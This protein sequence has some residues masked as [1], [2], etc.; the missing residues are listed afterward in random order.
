MADPLSK[1]SRV[2]LAA[3]PT[4]LTHAARF[5]AAIGADVWIKRD[6]V[7]ALGL[8]G[9]KVRKLEFLLAE[10]IAG[11]ADTIVT[12]GTRI[13]NSARAAAASCAQLGLRCVLIL[14]GEEPPTASGNL[15]LDA[16]FGA[17]LRYQPTIQATGSVRWDRL[18]EANRE[19][20][21]ALISEGLRPYV[22]PV[23]CSSPHA[24]LGFASGYFELLH[25][26]EQIHVSPERLYHASTS[27]GTHAGLVLGHLLAG[28]GPRPYGIGAADNV[29][30]DMEKRYAELVH[31]GGDLIG[32]DTAAAAPLVNLDM[33]FLGAG[34]GI[35]TPEGLEAVLLLARTEGILADPVY[36]G[37]ALAALVAAAR[38]GELTRPVVFWHTG[39]S[40]GVF[41]ADFASAL[42]R[43]CRAK[44]A[45]AI[46]AV[47]AQPNSTFPVTE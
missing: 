19:V 42:W 47:R 13:S 34:Y 14:G 1:V 4:P 27:G 29:Y 16:M 23:G 20:C 5:S 17:E 25:Q 2:R 30:P 40:P 6:D 33:S 32:V 3:L 24:V 38:R 46:T 44:T 22:L 31:A 37:K 21:A 26:L 12:L 10:A 39:G 45:E 7:G 36:T 43:L 11:G 8:A 18:D 15:L 9:N 28:L 41:E 35:V